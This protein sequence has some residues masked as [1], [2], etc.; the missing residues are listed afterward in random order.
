MKV[1]IVGAGAIGGLLAVKLAQAGASVSVVARGAHLQA[2]RERGLTLI[3]E[4]Q[5][6]HN[7]PLLA[8]ANIAEL[9]DGGLLKFSE[10]APEAVMPL[11]RTRGGVLGVNVAGLDGLRSGP[12]I[13]MDLRGAG[14]G[15]GEEVRRAM[16]SLS[17]EVAHRV[18]GMVADR[19]QRG[20]GFGSIF[21]G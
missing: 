7:V 1:C 6:E 8:S 16:A 21:D 20:G 11:T 2:I 10:T 3:A 17:D 9:A 14:P 15:V 5:R 4:D 12:T 19:R 18:L 13:H